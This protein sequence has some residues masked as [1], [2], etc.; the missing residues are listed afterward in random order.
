MTL[1]DQIA[2]DE[3]GYQKSAYQDSLGYWTIGF[4]R[5][6]DKR[7]DGGI[8]RAEAELMLDNDI[9]D[10]TAELIAALPWIPLIDPV[11]RAVLVNMAFNLGVA[12]LLGFHATLEAVHAGDWA[13]ASQH[14]LESKWA[15][16]VG[17]RAHRLADQMRTGEWQ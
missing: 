5:L 14:M 7:K 1:R 16:Q 3:G 9:R 13:A 17:P 10:K 8:S 12:G 11:R 15:Q 6:I 4:G 2:R